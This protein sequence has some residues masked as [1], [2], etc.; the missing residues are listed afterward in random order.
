LNFRFVVLA[1]PAKIPLY[2][3]E[4]SMTQVRAER[5]IE[6][7]QCSSVAEFADC[8]RIQHAIWGES[9]S[10][11]VPMFVVAHH[12]G[13]EVLGAFADGEMV[14]FTL[15]YAGTRSGMQFIH[16]HMAAVLPAYRDRGVGR[17]LKLRQRAEALKRGIG[18]I[19]WTFDP[20]DLKNGYFNFV[21]LGVIARRYIPN[22]YGV[23]DS[24]LHAGLPTDRLVSEWWLDSERVRRTLEG[25]P[26]P[27]AEKA[28]RVRFPA[29][30]ATMR[31]TNRGLA[32]RMQTE[33]REQFQSWLA[34][35]YAATNVES[36]ADATDYI[37]E[38]SAAVDGLNL[39]PLQEH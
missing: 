12:S 1:A 30:L 13:G 3:F 22:C 38:P 27:A 20:F 21:R 34:K 15:A 6:I 14:G 7:R 2:L 25:K 23:T 39:S 10:V 11:P 17:E 9:I 33:L 26:R 36:R 35:G 28:E 37:L 5:K 32:A 18:L 24:P 8:V 4:I 31:E 29:N 19:E 16:S